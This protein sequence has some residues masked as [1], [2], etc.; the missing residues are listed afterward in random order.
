MVSGADGRTVWDAARRSTVAAGLGAARVAERAA[1]AGLR[2][3]ARRNSDAAL[4]LMA[5]HPE[6]LLELRVT[7]ATA[8][9]TATHTHDRPSCHRLLT[10]RDLPHF[11]EVAVP[12]LLEGHAAGDR[13]LVITPPETESALRAHL[14]ACAEADFVDAHSWYQTPAQTM[15]A[16]AEYLTHYADRPG[17]RIIGEPAL[18]RRTADELAEWACYEAALNVA[19]PRGGVQ[20][21]CAYSAAALPASVT[22]EARRNHPHLAEHGRCP[23]FVK[24]YAYTPAGENAL[25]PA[26]ASAATTQVDPDNLA[27]VQRFV[28][29]QAFDAE[30]FGRHARTFG[31]AAR[32]VAWELTAETGAQGRLRVWAQRRGLVCEVSCPRPELARITGYLPPRGDVAETRGLWLARQLCHLVQVRTQLGSVV[33]RLHYAPGHG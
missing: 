13:L 12:F 4:E 32:E 10:Y 25:S 28:T 2:R 30:L 7:T 16:F 23:D 11:Q 21:I 22:T 1:T 6:P 31:L 15:A 5:A 18:A 26:P 33:A 20:T 14:P 8:S 29:R 3:R 9:G 19:F 24:P 27:A 17:L